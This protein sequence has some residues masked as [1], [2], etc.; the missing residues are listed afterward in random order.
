MSGSGGGGSGGGGGE[1][2]KQSTA[3][4][5]SWPAGKWLVIAVGLGIGGAGLWNVKR[6]VTRSFLDKLDCTTLDDAKQRTVEILGIVGYLARACAYAL[7][8]WFL[9]NAGWQHDSSE[10]EG[11]DGALR[12]LATTPQGPWLLRLL[13]LGLLVFGVYRVIDATLRRPT[14]IAYA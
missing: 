9:I 14:E 12:Q 13:A 3:L 7:V 2:E 8:A 11:L 5:L 4:V 10:T 1:K 6:A